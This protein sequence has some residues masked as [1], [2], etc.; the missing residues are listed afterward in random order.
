MENTVKQIITKC[1]LIDE[2]E[3]TSD[4]HLVEDLYADSLELID[5]IITINET[6]GTDIE[7]VDFPEVET[8][9]GLCRVLK[10]KLTE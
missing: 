7:G 5:I 2:A 4:T 9:R 6:F 8:V 3:I 10:R 1:L